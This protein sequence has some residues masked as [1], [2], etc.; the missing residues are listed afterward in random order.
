VKLR[1]LSCAEREFAEAVD[2]YNTQRSGLDCEFAV[3]SSPHPTDRLANEVIAMI[4]DLSLYPEREDRAAR[5]SASK[6]IPD[7]SSR[8]NMPADRM[9]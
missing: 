4:G 2:Y 7:R 3:R 5:G 6:G 9:D 1:V 8:L